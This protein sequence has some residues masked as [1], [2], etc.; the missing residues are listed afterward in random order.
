MA[1]VTPTEVK[2]VSSITPTVPV[3]DVTRSRLTHVVNVV[4]H[5]DT[6][7]LTLWA[8]HVYR[9]FCIFFPDCRHYLVACISTTNTYLALGFN[10]HAVR[11]D[12]CDRK[13]FFI[14]F[15]PC[16]FA[17]NAQSGIDDVCHRHGSGCLHCG[18]HRLFDRASNE[19]SWFRI[20]RHL[21]SVL[22]IV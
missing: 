21:S 15:G 22:S 18:T 13:P 17:K 6:V 14:A 12:V 5:H 20:D 4:F 2:I 9:I 8:L 11:P 16:R 1:K 3:R 19:A 7:P 10:R